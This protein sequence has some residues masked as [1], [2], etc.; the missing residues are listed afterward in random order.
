MDERQVNTHRYHIA[1]VLSEYN[2]AISQPY[3]H[4]LDGGISDNL[5]LRFLINLTPAGGGIWNQLEQF[6]LEKTNK[7][8][9]VVVNAETVFDA[10]FNRR[11][12][13]IPLDRYTFETME[14]VRN[15]STHWEESITAKRCGEAT[16]L[17]NSQQEGNANATPAC[18][19]Q[20]YLIE[21]NFDQLQDETERNHLKHL[22]TSFNL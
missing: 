1:K 14:M 8:A 22:P 20:T 7:L 11:D 4:M 12:Y 10:S 19:A 5:G 16:P 17:T 13:S 18:D 9:L 2:D 6:D 3:I 15:N 21:M